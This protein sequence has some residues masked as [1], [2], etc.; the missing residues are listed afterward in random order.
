MQLFVITVLENDVVHNH[1]KK[2]FLTINAY[3]SYAVT[4]SKKDA[5]KFFTKN[6]ALEDLKDAKEFVNTVTRQSD[7]HHDYLCEFDIKL[8]NFDD[9]DARELLLS[10][11]II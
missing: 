2:G 7:N 3:G 6:K 1:H 8:Q 9:R 4:Q 10:K 5:L 11:G